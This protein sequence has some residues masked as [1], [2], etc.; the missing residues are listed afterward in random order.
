MVD[1]YPALKMEGMALLRLLAAVLPDAFK[2]YAAAAVRAVAPALAHRHSKVR[3]AALA[4]AD[5][6]VTCPD[7]ANCRGA[8][9]EA[10]TDLVGFHD[11]NTIPIAAFYHGEPTVNRF[12]HLSSLRYYLLSQVV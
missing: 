7:K 11:P 1:P 2:I 3:L 12:V 5:A 8:G 9:T 10:I 4:A 6:F